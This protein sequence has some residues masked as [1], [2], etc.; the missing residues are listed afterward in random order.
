MERKPP[1]SRHTSDKDSAIIPREK[2]M[3]SAV[4]S[5]PKKG[6]GIRD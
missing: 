6:N 1:V 4:T 2:I 3:K 5:I